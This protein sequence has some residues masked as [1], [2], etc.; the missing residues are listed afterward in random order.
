M[1]APGLIPQAGNDEAAAHDR[2][3]R[4]W[5]AA[6]IAQF[7]DHIP[8]NVAGPNSIIAE[9]KEISFDPV[10]GHCRDAGSASLN[11][12][13]ECRYDR[14][15]SLNLCQQIVLV[16]H[17]CLR[18]RLAPTLGRLVDSG[19]RKILRVFGRAH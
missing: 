15:K 14:F 18:D 4:S 6:E 12:D 9:R 1:T 10:C 2:A 17:V 3:R 13:N 7:R 5:I 8:K 16:M 19:K 11:S